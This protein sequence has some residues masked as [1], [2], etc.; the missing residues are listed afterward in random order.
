MINDFL[1]VYNEVLSKLTDK[2]KD[3][4]KE[5][6]IRAFAQKMYDAGFEIGFYSNN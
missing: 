4:T 3:F 2:Q 1:K 6:N 5:E